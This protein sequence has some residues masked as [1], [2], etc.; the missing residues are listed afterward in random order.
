MSGF[1]SILVANRGEIA[2]RVMRT[3]KTHGYRTIAIYSEADA[4]APHVRFADDAVPVGPAPAAE[5]Y[6]SI[7]RVM[8]AA[9]ASGAEAV[10]PGYGFLSENAEFARACDAAGITYIGPHA[11]AIEVMG[12][13]AEAKR[14]M[15]AAGVPC[16]PG[17]QGE[18]QSDR[19]F[20]EA[21]EDIGF[22]VMIKA[23]A[24]GGGRGMRLVHTSDDFNQGLKRARREAL[25]A[26]GSDEL[27]L[28]KAIIRP[29]H[30]EVQVFGDRHGTIIHFGERDCSIQRRHQ[31]VIEEAP[32]PAVSAELRGLIGA[33]AV[34]AARS[35]D[36]D[37]AGTVEFLLGN[38][39][40]FYFLEM[41]TRL[42][43]EH[44]VTEMITGHDLVALQIAVAQGEP[45]GLTQ[46]DIELYGHAIEARLYA[47]D[48]AKGFLP[49][50]GSIELWRAPQGEGIRTDAGLETGQNISPYYDP[51]LAKIVAWG[52]SRDQA[53]RRLISALTQ[54]VLFGPASNRV[55]LAN[56]L[57]TP[58]FADGSATT[59]FI[60][61]ELGPDDMTGPEPSAEHAAAACVLR[62]CADREA[63]LAA[64]IGVSAA[65]CNWSSSGVLST[66]YAVTSGALT[67]DLR[68]SPT[69]HASYRVVHGD[70]ATDVDVLSQEAT[71][72]ILRVDG[73]QRRV[74]GFY[75]NG[76]SL[77]L[78]L[79]GHS[80]A[81]E[82]MT[83]TGGAQADAA[84]GSRVTAP[85]HG[86]LIE[87]L[88]AS[89]A[90]VSK[91]T[92]LAV[93]EA[94]KMQHE[95]VSRVDGKVV[96]AHCKAGAQVAAGDLLF[97]IEDA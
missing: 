13:K 24:G 60:E 94:M 41:N 15:I 34:E 5:S 45:L 58:G 86:N 54:T 44:P 22:P 53:R 18:N 59:A 55:F 28:E 25:N 72:A 35:I 23:A 87:V 36:Y 27:I 66:R 7:D 61:D 57:A 64:S 63:A 2:L 80:C 95:I 81:Y 73:R 76:R 37:N 11:D 65:L 39:G 74:D 4:E 67:F 47:E 84:D 17:Y 52:E 92:R 82:L 1:G 31:K 43:V 32:S 33:A 77:C 79:D 10:H 51:L 68:V 85:M 21:A 88:V 56:V 83:G 75:T 90:K 46:D 40:A 8:A 97:A 3:A 96:E 29:R 20:A 91:G 49:A 69:G 26:F 48:P 62:Y 70:G 12:N 14:R 38:D 50:T 89:G 16:V 6:L 42:Q 9:Q 71:A 30:V 93:L 19:A 78:S